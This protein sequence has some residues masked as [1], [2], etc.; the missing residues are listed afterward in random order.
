MLID[1]ESYVYNELRFKELSTEKKIEQIKK[2]EEKI[3]YYENE[4]KGNFMDEIPIIVFPTPKSLVSN[5]KKCKKIM[6][7]ELKK[8]NN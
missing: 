6:E 5:L 8:V 4:F 2:I 1:P 7:N 3:Y